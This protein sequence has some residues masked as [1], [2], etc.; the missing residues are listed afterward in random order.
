MYVL[1]PADKLLNYVNNDLSFHLEKTIESKINSKLIYYSV[2]NPYFLN[3]IYFPYLCILAV[4]TILGI[5]KFKIRML[6]NKGKY[7][8]CLKNRYLSCN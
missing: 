6:D 3:N 5:L 4:Y 2:C 1:T 7:C 8:S